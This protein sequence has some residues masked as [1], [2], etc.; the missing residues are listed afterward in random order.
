MI[1]KNLI[2]PL[3]SCNTTPEIYR[4][5]LYRNVFEIHSNDLFLRRNAIIVP[6][7]NKHTHT[8]RGGQKIRFNCIDFVLNL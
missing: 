3:S 1:H 8:R 6:P 2:F 7:H 5:F 4:D